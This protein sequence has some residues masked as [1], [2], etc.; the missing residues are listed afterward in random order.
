M[1]DNKIHSRY[2]EPHKI[3]LVPHLIVSK[4]SQST[5]RLFTMSVNL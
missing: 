2:S 1:D 5:V 3:Q 4:I